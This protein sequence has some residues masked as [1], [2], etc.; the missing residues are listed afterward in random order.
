[1]HVPFGASKEMTD[2]L[3]HPIRRKPEAELL[4]TARP[5]CIPSLAWLQGGQYRAEHL[6]CETS[7]PREGS[8]VAISNRF[9]CQLATEGTLP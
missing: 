4:T 8:R 5:M 3:S 7:S 2:M 9:D 6:D 1:M